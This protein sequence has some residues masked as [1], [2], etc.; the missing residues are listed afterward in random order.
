MINQE[1]FMDHLVFIQ[2]TIKHLFSD[3]FVLPLGNTTM[4]MILATVLKEFSLR[5][6]QSRKSIN[7]NTQL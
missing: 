1:G 4:N 3:S 2:Y 6:K 5:G 7:S